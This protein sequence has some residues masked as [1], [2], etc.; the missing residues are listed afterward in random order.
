[1]CQEET[2][3]FKCTSEQTTMGTTALAKYTTCTN[4]DQTLAI[5]KHW[6]EDRFGRLDEFEAC[7]H[8]FAKDGKG[9]A[10]DCMNILAS[11]VRDPEP[12]NEDELDNGAVETI[13][14]M[15][16]TDPEGICD[17]TVEANK[18]C[19]DCDKFSHFKILM[20][21]T[22][23]ACNSVDE[24]DCASWEEFATPCKEKL[25]AA[26]GSVDF[27]QE[28]QCAYVAN[29]CGGVGAFPTFRRLDCDGEISKESWDFFQY[30]MKGCQNQRYAPTKAPV[31]RI[32][33]KPSS[34]P[35]AVV[36]NPYTPPAPIARPT[37]PYVPP[38]DGK[39]S[40]GDISPSSTSSDSSSS[41][42]RIVWTGLLMG[43]AIGGYI[44]YKRRARTFT[45]A[46]HRPPTSTQVTGGGNYMGGSD[47]FAG[48]SV[49]SMSVDS[50]S[51]EPVIVPGGEVL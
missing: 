10:L 21:E 35:V 9:K 26:F 42:G 37:K 16:Y 36:P 15:L 29:D 46:Y 43:V 28:K 7:A 30:L 41:S 19:P 4:V 8:S 5:I 2:K 23:D 51:Y 47:L 25:H 33:Q 17:C 34:S 49:N 40:N 14:N 45:Y 18:I 50:T 32:I 48:L 31:A 22:L 1:M 24:V 3:S 27:S 38:P 39:H 44:F 6:D 12:Q 13:A 20:H 11:I